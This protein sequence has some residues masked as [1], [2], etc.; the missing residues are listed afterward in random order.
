MAKAAA[1]PSAVI[2]CGAGI[3][4]R[5]ANRRRLA[6]TGLR[7]YLKSDP[8]TLSRRLASSKDRPLLR[9]TS[10][11][12]TL[13]RQLVERAPWYEESEIQV[14]VSRLDPEAVVSAIRR[15]LPSPWSR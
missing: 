1:G 7:V 6:A 10:A 13:A 5:E 14:D 9:G 15:Q 3:V 4:L 8:V 2:S 11:E 12:K